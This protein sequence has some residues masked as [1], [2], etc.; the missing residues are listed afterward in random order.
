MAVPPPL[1]DKAVLRRELRAKRLAFAGEPQAIDR[2]L[3]PLLAR[4]GPIAG[5]M[6]HRGEPD[7]LPFLLRA[8]HLRHTVALPRPGSETLDFIRWHPDIVMRPGLAGISEPVGGEPI[9]PRIVLAPL[10]GFDRAGRRL[11]QGGGYY[12]RWFA[13]HPDAM[14]IGIAWS[15]QEVAALAPEAWDMPLHAIVTEKEWIAP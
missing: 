8:F 5:Y 9:V 12:D 1:P 14:R 3:A 10:V 13:G 2:L 6:A 11:G 4:E 15:V 7:V